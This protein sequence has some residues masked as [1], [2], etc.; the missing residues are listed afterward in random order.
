MALLSLSSAGLVAKTWRASTGQI[1]PQL[2]NAISLKAPR[3]GQV[4]LAAAA[5]QY[6]RGGAQVNEL[7]TGS[8]LALLHLGQRAS[9]SR[10][11][12]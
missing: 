11:S 3:L 6:L 9:W 4:A 1:E 5:L 2:D 10:S 7:N 12:R 8:A